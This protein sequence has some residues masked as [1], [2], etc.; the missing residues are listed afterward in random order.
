MPHQVVELLVQWLEVICQQ[1]QGSL[2]DLRVGLTLVLAQT[3]WV[4]VRVAADAV[5]ALLFVVLESENKKMFL[6]NAKV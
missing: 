6:F 2:A 5:E 4:A 1:L 3:L